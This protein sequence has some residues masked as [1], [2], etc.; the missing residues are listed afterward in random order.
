MEWRR[1]IKINPIHPKIQQKKS[2]HSMVFYHWVVSLRDEGS[3]PSTVGGDA[4][5]LPFIE[6]QMILVA[7]EGPFVFFRLLLEFQKAQ[8]KGYE[9]DV[10]ILLAYIDGW[11]K[12]IE[13]LK[14]FVLLFG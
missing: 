11:I 2:N 3:V 4:M 1:K 8:R 7:V 14:A 12:I 6:M 13:M 9:G 10:D 5:A